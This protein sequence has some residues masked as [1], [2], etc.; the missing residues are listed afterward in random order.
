LKFCF[1]HML[2][3]VPISSLGCRYMKT[4][5]LR[6]ILH[7]LYITVSHLIV[8]YSEKDRSWWSDKTQCVHW[9]RLATVERMR[10]LG[11]RPAQR[12]DKLLAYAGLSCKASHPSLRL[13]SLLN[14]VNSHTA[15]HAADTS[16]HGFACSTTA[17]PNSL[18]HRCVIFTCRP[19]RV[20]V[21]ERVR[22][23]A[24][25]IKQTSHNAPQPKRTKTP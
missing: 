15:A 4:S 25:A 20:R 6:C 7:A 3:A 1:G 16:K 9:C 11:M 13:R 22:V 12:G 14:S 10:F 5:V 2:Q 18:F 24:G 17:Q 8:P 21:S 23:L 19:R